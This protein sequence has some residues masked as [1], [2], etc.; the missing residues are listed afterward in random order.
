MARRPEGGSKVVSRQD[1]IDLGRADLVSFS[2]WP[3]GYEGQYSLWA[4]QKEWQ[5]LAQEMYEMKLADPVAGRNLCILAPSE[6]GKTY[7]L[8]IPFILWALGRD[9]NLRIAVVG[10]KDELAEKI[11]NGIDRLFKTR[12]MELAEFGLKVGHPWNAQEKHLVRDDDKMLDPSISFIGPDTEFQGRRYDIIFLTDFATFKNQR[13][14]EARAKLT[15][16]LNQSLFP[17]L[18]PWGFVMAEGHHVAAGDI[19]CEFE[20][21]EDEWKVVK[22]RAIIEE[23]TIEN[24]NIAKLLAPEHWSYKQL[25]RI[26]HRSPAVFQLIYQNIVVDLSATISRATLEAALDRSRPMVYAPFPELRLAYKEIHMGFDL[27]FST[28]RWSKYSV[29]VVVGTT[30][31]GR[32]DLL[33][34]WRLRMLP[35]QLRAKMISDIIKWSPDRIHIEANAAQIYV[36]YDVKTSLGALAERINPVY[37]SKDDPE[38][39]PEA[40]VGE[41]VTQFQT[42]TATLPYGNHDAQVISDQFINE[43][44]NYPGRYTDCVM[45]WA[46]LKQGKKRDKRSE[47]KTII[48]RGLT[49]SVSAQRHLRRLI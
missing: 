12:G 3:L 41:L 40:G 16:W 39:M 33:Y 15:D 13:S 4:C 42:M 2:R 17:R 49:R 29:C 18:E 25:S 26:R 32:D 6:H 19:Y 46:I 11:G 43:L 37:T 36:V 28:N 38:L 31:E 1:L 48:S 45:A 34:A 10:S 23:P 21:A 8:D 24:G 14:P 35:P 20:E 7:G 30:H 47:R 22:Y 5:E 9:R 27:A 44:A